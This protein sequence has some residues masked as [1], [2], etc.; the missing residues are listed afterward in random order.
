[1]KSNNMVLKCLE[2]FLQSSSIS[3]I[4]FLGVRFFGLTCC[5]TCCL[6]PCLIAWP[7]DQ[8]QRQIAKHSGGK[9]HKCPISL[10]SW[11]SLDKLIICYK[12][13]KIFD[14][15]SVYSVT[16]RASGKLEEGEGY[17]SGGCGAFA[18]WD[19]ASMAGAWIVHGSCMARAWLVGI[20]RVWL[21][22]VRFLQ[23]SF[24]IRNISTFL[25]WNLWISC[26][27]LDILISLN[28][29]FLTRQ[30]IRERRSAE[31]SRSLSSMSCSMSCSAEKCSQIQHAFTDFTGTNNLGQTCWILLVIC[32]CDIDVWLLYFILFKHIQT[33]FVNIYWS[34]MFI[35]GY[36][37]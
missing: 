2:R 35:L 31:S 10:R 15:L 18:V 12:L 4:C 20:C 16:F 24:D 37:T 32:W 26:G 27:S 11:S 17:V 19:Q 33:L 7:L 34:L 36:W 23:I 30:S 9:S 8:V 5:F 1:M 6:T 25:I 13:S 14:I 22:K 21:S 29:F 3:W 28:V